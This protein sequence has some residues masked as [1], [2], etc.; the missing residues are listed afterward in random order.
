M[1]I[2]VIFN[3]KIINIMLSAPI[4]QRKWPSSDILKKLS[5]QPLKFQD[6]ETAMGWAIQAGWNPGCH[7]AKLFYTLNS[8]HP[9]L[10]LDDQLTSVILVARYVPSLAYLGFYLAHPDYRGQG[11]APL[12]GRHAIETL[13]DCKLIA[14]NGVQSQA[15]SYRRKYGFIPVR[16][17]VRFQGIVKPFTKEPATSSI[18]LLN[19]SEINLDALIRYD[20]SVFC[21]DRTQLLTQWLT[22]PDTQ[23][24]VAMDHE[25]C[26]YGVLSACQNGYRIAPCFA[27]HPE[28]ASMIYHHLI[29]KLALPSLIQ[30]D[31]PETHHAAMQLVQ[32][33]ELQASLVTIR[34]Y[35]GDVSLIERLE[36]QTRQRVFATTTLE[37][38]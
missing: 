6:L 26:G 3:L 1:I 5:I 24:I 13:E 9:G 34:M 21:A 15:A 4:T 10:F 38:G 28:I 27:D 19:R 8:E 7:D 2:I 17:H 20:A 33:L 36:E 31:V 18:R 37:V 16:H 25:I 22:M 32:R 30:I 35:R 23:V 14:I 29:K 12:L 11:F